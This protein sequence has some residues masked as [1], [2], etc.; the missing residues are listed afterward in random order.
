M[1]RLKYA[2]FLLVFPVVIGSGCAALGGYLNP[3][4]QHP[5]SPGGEKVTQQEE[6]QAAKNL[7]KHGDSLAAILAA[8]GLP[9]IAAGVG[10]GTSVVGNVWQWWTGRKYRKAAEGAMATIDIVK[11][12][13]KEGDF[14]KS[15]AEAVVKE[16]LE[17]AGATEGEVR[18]V[19]H[20]LKQ[21]GVL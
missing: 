8:L 19:Y 3:G 4:A 11:D 1:K 14:T 15:D 17:Q 9:G 2:I 18:E 21:K 13:L 5:D 16:A 7:Q 10:A 12:R 20:L 6:K